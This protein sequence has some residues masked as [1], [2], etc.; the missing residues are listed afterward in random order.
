MAKLTSM[1]PAVAA[2]AIT[3]MTGSAVADDN[4]NLLDVAA[5]VTDMS[6]FGQ[7]LSSVWA[8]VFYQ[9]NQDLNM[10]KY[11]GESGAYSSAVWLYGTTQLPASY[12]PKW[13]SGYVSRA[14]ELY[15][16]TATSTESVTSDEG[17]SESSTAE[18]TSSAAMPRAHALSVASL[19]FV[20]VIAA[21]AFL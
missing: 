13:V 1:L 9:V 14:H 4:E 7:E 21:A 10:A 19:A 8:S 2:I 11:T 3:V 5:T 6:V 16:E 12:D 15:A 17:S 20:S 18:E